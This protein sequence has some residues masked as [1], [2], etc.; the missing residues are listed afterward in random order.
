MFFRYVRSVL[1]S[2]HGI[3]D[4][5]CLS[6][7]H[8]LNLSWKPA[9]STS[10]MSVTISM[11]NHLH[12]LGNSVACL[13]MWRIWCRFFVGVGIRISYGLVGVGRS[14]QSVLRLATVWTVRGPNSGEGE[15]FNAC[16]DRPWGLTSVL[17]GG[18]RVSF[19]GSQRPGRG[20]NNQPHLTRG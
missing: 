8:L 4:H 10:S 5:H 12:E 3:L 15:I 19:P 1:I 9:S 2:R 6:L 14:A 11:C 7:P 13:K 18:Y 17:Y 16:P 20:V